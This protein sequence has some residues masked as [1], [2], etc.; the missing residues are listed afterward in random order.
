M[1]AMDVLFEL[2]HW[3]KERYIKNINKNMSFYVLKFTND[4]LPLA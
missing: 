2:K 1:I 3:Q 4:L